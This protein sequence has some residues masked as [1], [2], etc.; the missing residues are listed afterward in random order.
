MSKVVLLLAALGADA[1][2]EKEFAADPVAVMDRFEL[3]HD[4]KLAMASGDETLVRKLD[5]HHEMKMVGKIIKVY[6]G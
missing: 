2:L 6:K 5:E 3:N 4:E 1:G